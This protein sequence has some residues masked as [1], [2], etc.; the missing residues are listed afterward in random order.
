MNRVKEPFDI[1]LNLQEGNPATIHI[2]HDSETFEFIWKG[3]EVSI[4]NNGDNSWSAIAN[5]LDQET[6]N[7]I[8]T[9][10]EKYFQKM[11]I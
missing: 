6:V 3:E 4:R 7:L 10:I 11:A 5:R 8:G 2:S 9:E 1:Q